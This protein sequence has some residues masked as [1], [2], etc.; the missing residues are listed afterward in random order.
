MRKILIVDDEKSIRQTFE[1]FLKQE[2]FEVLTADSVES[3]IDVIERNELDLIITDIIMPKITGIE[4][5]E[6]IKEK[7]PDIPIVIMT[8]EPTLETATLALKS[9]ADDY[10]TKPVHK[11]TLIKTVKFAIER[12]ELID[13]KKQL[14]TENTK[15][16]EGL[17]KLVE[18]RTNALQKA[19]LGTISTIA[20]IM[21]L[22]DP[23][24]AGHER[25]VGNLSVAIAMK[26]NL[27]KE[28]IDCLYVAGYIHDIGKMAIPTSILSKPGKLSEIELLLIK[29]HS[30]AGYEIL[31]KVYLPWHVAEVVYQHH[32]RIDGS[33]YPLGIKKDEIF[34][35]AKVMAVA[36]VI[37]AM[38]AHRPYRAALGL[39]VALDE[40]ESKSGTLYDE[41]V[42]EVA[43]ALFR[44][45]K[46]E[47]TDE[48]KEITLHI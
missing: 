23:Y 2:N 16:R 43:L 4:L 39:D 13:K 21:E 5:L 34:I 33:G 31:K 24:T 44:D 40:I 37:E 15:Y 36:D 1:I 12:K 9:S 27:P 20:S 32:E 45:D 29:T 8:G 47:F 22:R 17:E 7:T 35:E 11:D 25:R 14:E 38:T 41:K 3:A 48:S 42:A 26:M 10:L 46:Y 6:I 19:M 28:Q 30:D 18:K